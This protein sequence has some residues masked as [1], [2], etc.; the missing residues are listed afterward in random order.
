GDLRSE[1]SCLEKLREKYKKEREYGWGSEKLPK[2]EY[3]IEQKELLA[4]IRELEK[5]KVRMDAFL[6]SWNWKVKL[7]E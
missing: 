3:Q 5:K 7:K 1:L 6:S 4:K 2:F